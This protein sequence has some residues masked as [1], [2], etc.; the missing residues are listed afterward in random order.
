M[1]HEQRTSLM[2]ISVALK[3]CKS[4]EQCHSFA[5]T[6][7]ANQFDSKQWLINELT[8]IHT[9]SDVLVLGAWFPTMISYLLDLNCVS[10]KSLTCVDSDASV[11]PIADIYF[12]ALHTTNKTINITADARD[13][14]RVSDL[15]AYDTVINTSCEHMAFDMKEI[16]HDA[17]IVYAFQSNNYF[18]INGHINCKTSL[19]EFTEST[20]LTQI[21]YQGE[22]DKEKY[23][24][25][26]V[27]GKL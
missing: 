4:V 22:L 8:K 18:G 1:C 21:L 17:E 2:A 26:M 11:K 13:Y 15:S 23:T 27:I 16:I 12:N 7:T 9:L 6:F 20:G 3:Q 14:M 5:Q 19:N 24:R 10:Y 25:Y